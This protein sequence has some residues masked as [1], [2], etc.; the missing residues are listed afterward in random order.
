MTLSQPAAGMTDNANHSD[1]AEPNPPIAETHPPEDG[2]CGAAMDDV[3]PS[4]HDDPA[5]VTKL[6]ATRKSKAPIQQKL[7]KISTPNGRKAAAAKVRQEDI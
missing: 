2:A 6:A 4:G 5:R 7:G 3:E 1:D